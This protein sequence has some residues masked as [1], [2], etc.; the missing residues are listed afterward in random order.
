MINY[1][2]DQYSHHFRMGITCN[3]IFRWCTQRLHG[4]WSWS[5]LCTPLWIVHACMS[6]QQNKQ[7]SLSRMQNTASTTPPAT[8]PSSQHVRTPS[9]VSTPPTP[10]DGEDV[11]LRAV[12]IQLRHKLMMMKKDA[13]DFVQLYRSLEES[14]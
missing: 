2:S 5:G 12:N 3:T 1:C 14:M 10:Q 6:L 9:S 7:L 11:D 13:R 4:V 8:P